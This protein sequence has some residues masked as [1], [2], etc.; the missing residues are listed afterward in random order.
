LTAPLALLD[1]PGLSAAAGACRRLHDRQALAHRLVC[2]HSFNDRAVH[3]VRDLV[4]ELDGDLLEARAWGTQT[5]SS[6]QKRPFSRH[7]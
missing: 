2:L 5:R 4:R 1:Q 3:P 6:L 7:A